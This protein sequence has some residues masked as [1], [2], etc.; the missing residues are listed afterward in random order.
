MN[1]NGRGELVVDVSARIQLLQSS[2]DE[3]Q[4]VMDKLK[5]DSSGYKE[6]QRIF[7]S[8]TKQMESLQVQT[9]KTFSNQGQFDKANKTIDKIEESLIKAEMALEK[10]DFSQ[11]QVSPEQQA[12]FDK[13]K[14]KISEIK[15]SLEDFKNS[16]KLNLF[17]NADFKK[18]A[19]S[20][21]KNLVEKNFDEVVKAVERKTKEINDALDKSEEKMRT[22]SA[23]MQM[24]VDIKNF[25][26]G[27]D[28]E[29]GSLNLGNLDAEVA[30][31]ALDKS[32]RFK[33]GGKT[34]L[35]EYLL[36]N[37]SLTPEQAQAI[38]D[39]TQK[40]MA[41]IM[42]DLD[43]WEPQLKAASKAERAYTTESA[44]FKR[45]SDDA[46]TAAVGVKELSTAQENVAA[47]ERENASATQQVNQEVKQL[48]QNTRDATVATK[49][50]V[51][52]S[53][54]ARDGVGALHDA[55]NQSNES[56]NRM[57]QQNLAFD[58]IQ[59]A[60]T[61]FMGFNQVLN[62]T[63]N[64]VRE[65]M[66]H[67]K[68]LDTTMNGIAIVS[69]MT[70][71]D[72]WKQV[73]VYSEMAQR[74]G[75]SIQGAYEVSKIYYQ[76]GYETN[77]VLTLMNETL[78]MSKISG[79]DYATTT[80]Y[81][82]NA[83]RG[84]KLEVEDASRVVDVYSGLAQ[85]T[86]VSQEELAEAMSKTASSMEGVGSTFEETSAMIATMTAV[87]RESA[88]NIGSSLKSIASRYGELTKDP[89]ALFDAEGDEMNFNKV[90]EALKSVGIS[91][92]TADNQFRSFTGVVKELSGVWNTLDSTQQRY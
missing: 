90:D 18:F 52:G 29:G 82:M 92:H 17:E 31:Q 79:L 69:D 45:L 85:N 1:V 71:E 23:A 88:N 34:I 75:T 58:S 87:T 21:D 5:P 84:F 30:A 51:D 6:L 37:F 59:N 47:K 65:A 70:T 10:I 77:D 14:N 13:L 72:L 40:E 76:A 53:S 46:K 3:M 57:K 64:A 55:V 9:S 89:K 43:F 73:D 68:Q 74:Y 48:E 54:A 12:E 91:M 38:K 35:Y 42:G 86:A 67:I 50:F 28:A 61:N 15:K 32:G 36:A 39:K 24:G 60:I 80:D 16:E 63:R 44:T 81:M 22:Y 27:I 19:D 8:L 4:K 26:K 20:I 83:L 2:I 41:Q 49:E 25:V 56:F 78:K 7:A 62:I 66:D 33:S 11:I